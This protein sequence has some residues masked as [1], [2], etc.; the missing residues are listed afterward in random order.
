MRTLL[1]QCGQDLIEYALLLSL[2]GLAAVAGMR[3]VASSLSAAY[4]NIGT[5][6][7]A[8]ISNGNS[9]SPSS[10]GNGA[11]NGQ[12]NNGNNNGQGNNGDNGNG[13]GNG[14]NGNGKG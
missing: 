5:A 11:G 14:N 3:S 13:T 4:S 1:D 10:N 12:G 7:V 6:F 9:A 8:Y 2:V